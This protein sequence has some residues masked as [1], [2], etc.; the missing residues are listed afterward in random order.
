MPNKQYA[1]EWI[2]IALHHLESAKTLLDADHFTDIIGL[3]L[4]QAIEKICRKT[5]QFNFK[6]Y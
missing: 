6:I 3:E 1:K 4:H 5:I 2:E